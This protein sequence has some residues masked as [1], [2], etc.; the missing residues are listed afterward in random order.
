MLSTV[1]DTRLYFT[2]LRPGCQLTLYNSESSSNKI[3]F[4]K[5]CTSRNLAFSALRHPQTQRGVASFV[6]RDSKMLCLQSCCL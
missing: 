2:R 3:L 6:T 5:V 4:L 1:E